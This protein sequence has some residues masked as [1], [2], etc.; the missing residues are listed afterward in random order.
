[1]W[2]IVVNGNTTAARE[3]SMACKYTGAHAI[4]WCCAATRQ[5][6]SCVLRMYLLHAQLLFRD[7]GRYD[8]AQLRFAPGH[9]L[10]ENFYVRQV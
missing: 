9:K 4:S 6:M 2:K 10:A 1:M 3:V 7:Y 8:E 5:L